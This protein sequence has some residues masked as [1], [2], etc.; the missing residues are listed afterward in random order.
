MIYIYFFQSR[1]WKFILSSNTTPFIFTVYEERFTGWRALINYILNCYK[2]N[3]RKIL[4]STFFFTFPRVRK[5]ITYV[6][7]LKTEAAPLITFSPLDGARWNPNNGDEIV[8]RRIIT[9]P[10]SKIVIQL[11]IRALCRPSGTFNYSWFRNWLRMVFRTRPKWWIAFFGINNRKARRRDKRSF[12]DQLPF[13]D[14]SF[15]I[16][17]SKKNISTTH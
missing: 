5:V 7:R 6:F 13:Q 17:E 12:F 14:H 1:S 9:C 3:F 2:R 15:D 10:P 4:S 16:S 8:P 11:R